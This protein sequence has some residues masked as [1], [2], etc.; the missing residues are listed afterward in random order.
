MGT[1]N[2]RRMM[3]SPTNTLDGSLCLYGIGWGCIAGCVI[4]QN[5]SQGWSMRWNG[6][7][8]RRICGR[9]NGRQIRLCCGRVLGI[10]HHCARW[11]VRPSSTGTRGRARFGHD[12]SSPNPP[13]PHGKCAPSGGCPRTVSCPSGWRSPGFPH[14]P[15]RTHRPMSASSG[16]WS[17]GRDRGNF[18]DIFPRLK[19]TSISRSWGGIERGI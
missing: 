9:S 11:S 18:S 6:I 5:G 15:R 19:S 1:P 8:M 2:I 10:A 7:R 12:G 17:R 16:G 14:P 13:R 3:I 4:R